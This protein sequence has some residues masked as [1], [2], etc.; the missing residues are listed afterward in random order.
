M[1]NWRKFVPSHNAIETGDLRWVHKFVACQVPSAR[2]QLKVRIR[3][4]YLAFYG[5]FLLA[6]QSLAIPLPQLEQLAE[7]IS[8]PGN[9]RNLWQATAVLS[10]KLRLM[11]CSL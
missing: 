1:V 9:D 7:C 5:H 10:P 3:A 2:V 6:W 8:W 4:V 11:W